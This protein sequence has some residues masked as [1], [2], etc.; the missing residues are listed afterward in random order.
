M[1]KDG[2]TPAKLSA[3]FQPA[4]NPNLD[5]APTPFSLRLTRDERTRLDTLAGVQPLG[6]FTGISFWVITSKKGAS[7]ASPV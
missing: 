1:S 7:H 3:S 6:V 2:V 4:S 5:K